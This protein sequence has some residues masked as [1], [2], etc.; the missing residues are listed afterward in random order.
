MH[1]IAEDLIAKPGFNEFSR[2]KISVQTRLANKV[3][4]SARVSF[5]SQVAN[6]GNNLLSDIFIKYINT[7]IYYCMTGGIIGLFTGMSILSVAELAF[8][9]FKCI[10]HLVAKEQQGAK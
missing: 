2:V 3:V 10:K 1:H 7:D 6:L 9:I 4:R 5:S 8:W